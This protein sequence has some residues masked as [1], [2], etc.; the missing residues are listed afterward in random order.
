MREFACCCFAFVVIAD[1][2][3][4][5]RSIWCPRSGLAPRDTPRRCPCIVYPDPGHSANTPTREQHHKPLGRH[6]H[7]D[8]HATTHQERRTRWWDVPRCCRAAR[9][10]APARP[11]CDSRRLPRHSAAPAALD[12]PPAKQELPQALGKQKVSQP[13]GRFGI[14]CFGRVFRDCR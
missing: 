4:I 5:P 8:I 12:N 1:H 10:I 7:S 2:G 9:A 11:R 6:L 13:L 14:P 3:L